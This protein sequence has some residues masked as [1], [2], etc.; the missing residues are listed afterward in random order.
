MVL[1]KNNGACVSAK[2]M[3]P[4][5]KLLSLAA[6]ALGGVAAAVGA[7]SKATFL[8]SPHLRSGGEVARNSPY[9]SLLF[10][11]LPPGTLFDSLVAV[12]HLRILVV[13]QAGVAKKAYQ[14]SLGDMPV[15]HK[16]FQGD[17]RTPE[18]LYHITDRNP[19]S[20][21]H[22]NLG[23]SYP[24]DADRAYAR[25]RGRSPGGDIKIHGLPNGQGDLGAAH[26]Q[27]DWTNGCIAVTDDE[28]DELYDRVVIGSPIL[29]LP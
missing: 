15:G 4:V 6:L 22:K 17:E 2:M 5:A 16:R 24:N 19:N 9:D 26:L 3:H 8:I 29:I 7:L 25:A 14:F 11:A 18:G 10:R 20:I 23:I 21:C 27:W 12:K 13:Y 28:V 1:W